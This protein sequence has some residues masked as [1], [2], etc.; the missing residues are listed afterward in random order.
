MEMLLRHITQAEL[1][2]ML[3]RHPEASSIPHLVAPGVRDR[4]RREAKRHGLWRDLDRNFTPGE[5]IP[6][7][8][9]SDFRRFQRTGNRTLHQNKAAWRRR[10][11]DQ[12]T[13]A[14][15]LDHPKAD[16]DY[17]QDLLWAYCDD[18]T[19]IMAAHEYCTIDLGSAMLGITF[20]ELLALLGERLED[21][22]AS[23]LRSEIQRR[24]LDAYDT[25]ERVDFWDTTRMNWNHVC[26][27]CVL[28]TA[29]LLDDDPRRLACRIHPILQNMTYALDGF[30][31]DGG[32]EE[33][34]GYWGFGFGH[35]LYAAH[36][37]KHRTGGE[38]D[39]MAHEKV[40]RICRFPLTAHIGG[41]LRATFSDSHHGWLSAHNALLI[42]Q[43]YDLPDLYTLC[44][45]GPGKRPR[46]TTL[47]ELALSRGETAPQQRKPEDHHLPDMGFANLHSGPLQLIVKAGHNDQP[48]NHN[49]IGSFMLVKKGRILLTDPG[50]PQYTAKT[51]S[52][53][54]YEI[55]FCRSRGHSVPLINGREQKTGRAHA[56]PVTVENLNG[57]GPKTATVEMARAYPR[58]T[59]KA[60]TRTFTLGQPDGALGLT[61]AYRFSRA[62]QALEEAFITF[63]KATRLPGGKGVQVGPRRGGLCLRCAE[64]GT[65]RV[66]H[67]VEESKEGARPDE[68]VTRI[69]FTPRTRAKEMTLHFTFA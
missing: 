42:N 37:L 60:L 41:R 5:D 7:L 36:A 48:H 53:R 14:L 58:G 40:A 31:D 10:T 27:G 56:G 49:D 63:E 1:F 24:I 2:G 28:R 20:A 23:R 68:V 54:R 34:P 62:P 21:E 43:V 32:C 11:L 51:F 18:H 47:H 38:L 12:A 69:T 8:R 15:W 44:E 25:P 39:L 66:E 57:R 6:V 9:H 55:L 22:V 17:L 65:W 29:L 3:E 64:A 46:L 35:Y 52:P 45:P 13:L 33:G 50:G 16:L 59:V 4:A 19:W 26:N 30:T 67:L 61:D